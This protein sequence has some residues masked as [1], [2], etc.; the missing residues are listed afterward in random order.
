[1]VWTFMCKGEKNVRPRERYYVQMTVD[2]TLAKS[3]QT[4]AEMER[5]RERGYGQKAD[6][7]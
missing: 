5:H 3:R 6:D 7:D 2:G 4:K 1:M